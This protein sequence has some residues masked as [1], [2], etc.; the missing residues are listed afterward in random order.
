VTPLDATLP[1][2]ALVRTPGHH[3]A[4][5]VA[6]GYCFIN[7]AAIVAEAALAAGLKRVAFVDWDVHHGNG[8]Q[9]GFYDR[10]DVV[11]VSIHMD[12]G[13]WDRPIC[14]RGEPRSGAGD[15]GSAST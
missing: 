11:T 4:R 14:R 6:D 12:H 10:S 8:T 7:N 5:A 1:A 9:D 15:E 2:L 3:A 13:A